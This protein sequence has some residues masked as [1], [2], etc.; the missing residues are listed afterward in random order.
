MSIK[1]A[2]SPAQSILP[3]STA[4]EMQ[5]NCL[6]RGRTGLFW[7]PPKI[8]LRMHLR[9]SSSCCNAA[10]PNCYERANIP[11]APSFQP[12]HRHPKT[13]FKL[14]LRAR[15]SPELQWQTEKAA[16]ARRSFT[17]ARIRGRN[18]HSMPY[19]LP[20]STPATTV[21]RKCTISAEPEPNLGA[22]QKNM[23][24]PVDILEIN[25]MRQESCK[26]GGK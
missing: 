13:R 17:K 4:I 2:F 11:P 26:G 15:L 6:Y 8:A 14:P 25:P 5:V 23:S 7:F 20:S 9:S 19:S 21:K 16:R 22:K 24:L 10:S 3:E 1:P 18:Y 12:V